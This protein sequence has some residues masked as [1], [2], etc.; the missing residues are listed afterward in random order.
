MGRRKTTLKPISAAKPFTTITEDHMKKQ[1]KNAVVKRV[2]KITIG[3]HDYSVNQIAELSGVPQSTLSSLIN[4]KTNNIMVF[5]LWK[6]CEFRG[7]SLSAFFKGIGDE[8]ERE[9]FDFDEES[10]EE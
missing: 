6:L 2:K 10:G 7:I 3:K 5:T 1:L 4:G 8:V 9:D